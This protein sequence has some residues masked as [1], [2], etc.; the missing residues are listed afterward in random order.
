MISAKIKLCNANISEVYFR[1]KLF[2]IF[3]LILFLMPVSLADEQSSTPEFIIKNTT[4]KVLDRVKRD[5]KTLQDDPGEMFRLVSDLIFP[6]FDFGVMSRFVMG[7]TWKSM[8]EEKKQE[9]AEHFR[10]LLVRTYASAL[11]EFSD[12]EIDYIPSESKGGGSRTAK[13]LQQIKTGSGEPM[14]ISYRLHNRNS[15]WK[16]YDVSVSGVSLVKT[17]RASFQS[18]TE[19]QGVDALI[20][21][22]KNKNQQYGNP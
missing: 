13:V 12:Q 11:L 17:Y 2:S 19:S 3:L 20:E 8:S 21:S 9:F 4:E 15:D 14:I 22:L 6:H 16:V 18:I 7:T 5:K 10:R 1:M